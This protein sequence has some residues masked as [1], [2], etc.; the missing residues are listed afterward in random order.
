MIRTDVLRSFVVSIAV[1]CIFSCLSA[2]LT[3]ICSVE[4][5]VPV[6][7][8]C[9]PYLLH[10]GGSIAL[11]TLGT[12]RADTATLA[13]TCAFFTLD[14]RTYKCNEMSCGCALLDTWYASR[15][16]LGDVSVQNDGKISCG[17]SSSLSRMN[18]M[19]E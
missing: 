3:K 5:S 17:D 4:A 19:S 12:D 7:M 13:I 1:S 15:F 8:S 11:V 6:V 18:F 10:F 9:S 14:T 2:Y 16:N